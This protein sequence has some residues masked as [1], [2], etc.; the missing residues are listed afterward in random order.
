[1]SISERSIDRMASSLSEDFNVFIAEFYH[2]QLSEVFADAANLFIQA[3][4]GDVDGDLA[5]ALALRLIQTQYINF[6][7]DAHNVS[8]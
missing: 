6:E 4:L 7:P 1:M 2:E 5:A 3:E 8:F